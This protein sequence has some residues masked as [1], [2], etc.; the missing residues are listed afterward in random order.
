MPA[1]AFHACLRSMHACSFDA[2]EMRSLNPHCFMC[3]LSL[4]V[5]NYDSMRAL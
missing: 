4:S 1:D 5:Q 2:S 3:T